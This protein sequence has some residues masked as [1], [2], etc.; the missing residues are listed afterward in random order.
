MDVQKL[1]QLL[2]AARDDDNARPTIIKDF[3]EAVFNS[4][5]VIGDECA[6]EIFRDLAWDLESYEPDP[7]WRRQDPSFFGDRR[8]KKLLKSAL[9]ALERAL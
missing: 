7:I 8:A 6:D 5:D 1:V 4:S 9:R 2:I 3:Q